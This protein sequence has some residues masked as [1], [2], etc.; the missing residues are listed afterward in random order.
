MASLIMISCLGR[1][2][3]EDELLRHVRFPEPLNV[4]I[5]GKKNLV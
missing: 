3:F 5:D 2:R 1:D 4:M